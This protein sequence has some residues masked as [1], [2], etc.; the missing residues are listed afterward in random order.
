MAD[1]NIGASVRAKLKNKA[2]AQGAVT[3]NIEKLCKFFECKV[4]DVMEYVPD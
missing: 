4:Q 2:Q 3:H 1:K